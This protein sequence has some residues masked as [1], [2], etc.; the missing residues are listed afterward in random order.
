MKPS[1]SLGRWARAGRRDLDAAH[2]R[3]T[4]AVYRAKQ[5]VVTRVW[6]GAGLVMLLEPTIPAVMLV[7]LFTTFIAFTILDE[8]AD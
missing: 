8:T 1:A 3:R 4:T 6:T 5:R 2:A 7:S